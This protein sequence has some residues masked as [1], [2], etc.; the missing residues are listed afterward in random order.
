MTFWYSLSRVQCHK[1][2]HITRGR[3]AWFRMYVTVVEFYEECCAFVC[4]MRGEKFTHEM[5]KYEHLDQDCTSL[6]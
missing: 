4:S 1:C 5:N 3:S 6:R 2:K